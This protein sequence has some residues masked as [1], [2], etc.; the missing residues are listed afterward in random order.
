MDRKLQGFCQAT[1][2]VQYLAWFSWILPKRR[3][4][5]SPRF[6]NQQVIIK[7]AASADYNNFKRNQKGPY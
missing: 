6:R 5:Q 1:K 7:Q 3:K 4:N 2:Q